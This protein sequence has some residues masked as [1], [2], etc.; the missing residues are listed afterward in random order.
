MALLPFVS[1]LWPIYV[2]EAFVSV[3]LGFGKRAE[4]T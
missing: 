3:D 1:A 2:C 4:I